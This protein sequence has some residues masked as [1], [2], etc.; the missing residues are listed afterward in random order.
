[1]GDSVEALPASHGGSLLRRWLFAALLILPAT[2]P[3]LNHYLAAGG[4][5]LPT[6][7]IQGDQPG[8][9]A[10]ARE[11][12]DRGIHLTYS[13]PFVPFTDG[14][15]IYFQ[16]QTFLLGLLLFSTRLDPGFLFVLF[17]LVSALICA[18]VAV[19][20]YEHCAGSWDLPA[21]FGVLLFFWGGGFFALAGAL[22]S[23]L[24]TFTAGE[25][26]LYGNLF[27]W[28]PFEGWW[29][30][31]FG[32]NLIM[33]LE[34]Y[35]HATFFGAVLAYLREKYVLAG[36]LLVLLCASHPYSGS[37]L[38]IILL[39]WS[40]AEGFAFAPR[41]RVRRF[42]GVA[43]LIGLLHVG[44]YLLFLP[45][46]PEHRALMH[47]WSKWWVLD[48]RSAV[49]GYGL[50]AL[51]AVAA[52]SRRNALRLRE[53]R[54][55]LLWFLVALVLVKHELFTE[56]PIE[57]LHFTRGY[58]WTPL[59]L[60]GLPALLRVIRSLLR[61]R[62]FVQ[63]LALG[64]LLALFLLD[65]GL[66][67]TAV[68]RGYL[69]EQVRTTPEQREV[70]GVLNSGACAGSTVL[71]PDRQVALLSTVYSPL[72]PWTTHLRYTDDDIERREQVQDLILRG[73]SS[74]AWAGWKLAVVLDRWPES[75]VDTTGARA[76][77]SL[78][79]RQHRLLNNGRYTVVLVD[80]AGEKGG[81]AENPP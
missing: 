21:R 37:E 71:T 5:G 49:F 64:A 34:A 58:V 31:N 65:N 73:K 24:H 1:M 2:V 76:L 19:A 22:S 45:S 15:S 20:L 57:P 72:R 38:L 61:R 10:V 23:P 35:Y 55:L 4:E 63:V 28:D 56:Y 14:P 29:F 51:F 74:E 70:F 77:G 50:V 68:G 66:W 75:G 79:G 32:R 12:F 60:L 41:G 42:F 7:F 16:P 43:V 6:G 26:M 3:Y 47:Q 48:W 13:N 8:Y 59:F 62:S 36:A 67:L 44:Y 46:F 27:R 25:A 53:N 40:A 9:M 30:L 18:R 39:V 33:P 52:L 81:G 80:R 78:G 69:I 54:L 17:G 11:Y